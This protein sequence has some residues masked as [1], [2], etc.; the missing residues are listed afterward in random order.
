MTVYYLQYGKKMHFPKQSHENDA[1][2]EYPVERFDAGRGES[3][4]KKLDYN[5][6]ISDADRDFADDRHVCCRICR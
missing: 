4:E 3:Y 2:L 1:R 6:T 5:E